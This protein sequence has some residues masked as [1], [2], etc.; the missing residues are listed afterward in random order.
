MIKP[1]KITQ[2]HA[3]LSQEHS[4]K[5]TKSV[6]FRHS[7]WLFVSGPS[8]LAHAKKRKNNTKSKK[9]ICRILPCFFKTCPGPEVTFYIL[10]LE[11]KSAFIKVTN[12][13]KKR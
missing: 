12:R 8:H 5:L 1:L 3:K 4:K 9:Y 6:V 11:Y 13:T 7:K 10:L 2:N